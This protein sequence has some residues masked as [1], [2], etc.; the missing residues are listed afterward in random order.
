MPSRAGALQNRP[1]RMG[2]GP[3]HID[4]VRVQLSWH[5]RELVKSND[6]PKVRR[7]LWAQQ[8]LK[9]PSE[10]ADDAHQRVHI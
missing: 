8:V 7:G 5:V 10:E 1:L 2:T 4:G 3:R 6:P 9:Q